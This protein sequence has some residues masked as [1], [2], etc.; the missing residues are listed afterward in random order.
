MKE[1][2]TPPFKVRD[3]S[4]AEEG[5]KKIDWAE[6][7]MP[8]LMKLRAEFQKTKPLEGQRIAGCLH[9][10]KETAVLVE[11]LVAAGADVAWC[12]C[13]P[14]STND[15]VAAALAANGI[16]IWAWHGMN[17]EEYYWA[18]DKTLEFEPT[19]T[20][21][22]GADLIFRVHS[23]FPELASKIIGG[24]EETTTGVHRLR[25][26]DADN[27]LLYPVIAVNDTPTK[28]EFDNVYGTGQSTL[29][30]ILRATSILLAGKNV[31]VAGYGHCGRGVANRAKGL[32]A[33]VI[34]TEVDPIN[35]LKATLEGFRV[36]KMKDAAKIGDVF[37][38]ATGMKDVITLEH[39][40]TMK[41]GAIV[42]NTGH[43]DVEIQVDRLLDYA[44][45][46]RTIRPNNEEITM[47]EGHRIYLLARGRLVNLAAAEG[48]PS[49]VMDMS[50]SG[51]LLSLVSLAQGTVGKEGNHVYL[52][53]KELDEQ[54]ARLKLE[55]MGF[56][57]DELTPEQEAYLHAY[58]E[59][60]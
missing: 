43:Y 31:V 38:T 19:L 11:T 44:S 40:K 15:E 39:L 49:E 28:W 3:I 14:L 23:K 45:N 2:L 55:L 12:G 16:N 56:E 5:Q 32:G 41:D 34:V 35:A 1:E 6:S 48:H 29:D 52:L 42:C 7:R 20:L 25:A 50:F 27:K 18:I 36:M 57:I 26:M 46:V 53:P 60:T 54:I 10:T 47:P 9:V 22:D 30:G 58:D 51:Q 37:I 59:G 4:L 21:D 13:N 8:V 24:T 33:N 17:T